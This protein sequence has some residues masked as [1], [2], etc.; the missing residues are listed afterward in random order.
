MFDKKKKFKNIRYHK[1]S[2]GGTFTSHFLQRERI[3]VVQTKY[4]VD[5]EI[6]EE[7]EEILEKVMINASQYFVCTKIILFR[8]KKCSEISSMILL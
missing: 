2:L 1:V 5:S 8:C 7:I 4:Y 3:I 6:E